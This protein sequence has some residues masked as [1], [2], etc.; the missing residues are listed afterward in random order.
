MDLYNKYRPKKF[1]D[2]EGQNVVKILQAQVA[3]GMNAHSFLLSG[4]SGTGKTTLARIISMALMCR[5]RKAGQSEPCGECEP[6]K[7]IQSTCRDVMEINCA[8]HGGVGEIRD[9]ISERMQ[10]SPTVGDY[11]I[12]L[13]D[14]CHMLTSQAQNALL[15][16]LEEPP[17]YV[18]FFLCTTDK[19][20]ILPTILT[21]CQHYALTR[22]STVEIVKILKKIVKEEC[23]DSDEEGIYLIA[24]TA[25]G[26]PRAALSLLES[27]QA[28]GATEEIVRNALSRAP[29]QIALNILEAISK[30]DRAMAIQVILAAEAEGRDLP[31]LLEECAHILLNEMINYK[32]LKMDI[33]DEKVKEL[34]LNYNGAQIIDISQKLLEINAKIRQNAPADLLTKAGLLNVIDRFAKLKK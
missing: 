10:Y 9:M 11:R 28:S 20:K 12:F 1:E 24:E 7:Q 3:S 23:I 21:R 26:S 29:R 27:I 31:A 8:T 34:A 19:H 33:R 30:C 4:P 13:L 25:K 32:L 14:E 2:V 15:K 16:I 18:K 22:V 6:C 17:Q 5:N